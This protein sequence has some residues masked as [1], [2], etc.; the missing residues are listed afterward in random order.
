VDLRAAARVLAEH[1]DRQLEALLDEVDTVEATLQQQQHP[2]SSSSPAGAEMEAG[3]GAGCGT[4]VEEYDRHLQQLQGSEAEVMHEAVQLAYQ[5]KVAALMAKTD[6]MKTKAA[7]GLKRRRGEQEEEE[8]EGGVVQ[9]EVDALLRYMG[10]AGAE[11][12]PLPDPSL[13]S[14]TSPPEAAVAGGGQS[15]G[16]DVASSVAEALAKKLKKRKRERKLAGS[17]AGGEAYVPLDFMDWTS[18]VI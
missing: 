14:Q 17:E 3:L 5:A 4:L 15:H 10:M 6:R 12:S 13:V 18:K 16:G 9:G 7:R 2:S 11:D 8:G 1:E